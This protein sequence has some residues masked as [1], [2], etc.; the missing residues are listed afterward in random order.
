MEWWVVSGQAGWVTSL[1]RFVFEWVGTFD[2]RPRLLRGS[3]GYPAAYLRYPNV[4]HRVLLTKD[5]G[6]NVLL[7]A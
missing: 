2:S 3:Q 5:Q 1:F 6:I 4:C 7:M